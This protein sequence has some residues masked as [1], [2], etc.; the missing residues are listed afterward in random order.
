[1]LASLFYLLIQVKFEKDV[2]TAFAKS[3][4]HQN[5]TLQA[6]ADSK[7]LLLLSCMCDILFINYVASLH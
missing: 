5:M 4:F 6:I 7:Q 3:M 1:M 2:P